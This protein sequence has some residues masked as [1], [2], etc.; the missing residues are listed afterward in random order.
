MNIPLPKYA[1]VNDH[2]CLVYL[3][4][5]RELVKQLEACRP[6]IEAQLAGLRVYLSVREEYASG[7]SIPPKDMELRVAQGYFG[8]VYEVLDDL[9][10]N[11]VRRLMDESGL[12]YPDEI[13][14]A[15]A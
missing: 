12:S 7:D 8:F 2:V 4:H 14:R 1:V 10:E 11:P 3:G 15:A 5:R 9:T 13:F 6:L